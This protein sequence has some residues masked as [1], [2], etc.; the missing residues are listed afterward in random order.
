MD[1]SAHLPWV[2]L[3]IRTAW[4]P[5]SSFSPAEAVYGA[6]PV[7]PGQYLAADDESPSPTFLA[8]LQGLLQGRTLLS[9]THHNTPAPL[10]LPEELLLARH[11]LIRRDGHAPPLAA[12]YDGPYLVLERSL[13]FFKLQIGDRQERVSTLRLKPCF[14]PP[15]VQ[16]AQPP[17]RGR[18][19]N[20]VRP[21]PPTRDSLQHPHTHHSEPSA[22]VSLSDALS[23]LQICPLLHNNSGTLPAAP[24]APRGRQSG[25]QSA[26]STPGGQGLGGAVARRQI[27]LCGISTSLYVYFYLSSLLSSVYVK[28]VKIKYSSCNNGG[29]YLP[30]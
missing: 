13:R 10:Q 2:M 11:V 29:C 22:I 14:S 19:P 8:D 12:T 5:D 27:L 24:P 28:S 15:D 7:L 26:S 21:P 17:R 3:G 1:W 16:V 9:T 20:A 25:T 4:R 30:G 6:Q 23:S 18:P